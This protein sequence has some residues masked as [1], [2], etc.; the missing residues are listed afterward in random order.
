VDC[1]LQW[2]LSKGIMSTRRK[3]WL[4]AIG[5]FALG[6]LAA[7]LITA[8]M[9]AVRYQPYI[10]E[11]A[12][13]YL[14]HR[15]DSEVELAALRVVMPKTSLFRMAMTRGRG[16]HARVEG[17]GILMRHRGRRDIPPMF[18]MKRFSFEVDLGTVFDDTKV[19]PLVTLE[20]MEITIP[21]KGERPA[22]DAGGNSPATDM[23]IEVMIKEVVISDA[24]LTIL[25]KDKGKT[26][27]QFD[28]H[29]LRL[30]SAGKGVAMNYDAAL[31][32]AKPPGEIL[33]NGHLG[34][35]VAD[36]PGNTPLEGQYNFDKADLG[37]FKGIAGIL[38]STG[39][40]TGTLDSI[41]A[42]GK[43]S[44]PDFRLKI[45][46]NRVPLST[47]FEAL[48]D[49]TN[50]NTVLKPVVAKLGTTNFTTS[51]AII[52]HEGH[53]F[54]TISLDVLMPKGNLKDLLRL[55]L[56]GTPFMEGQIALKTKIDIPPLSGR[57]R[58]KLQLAGNFEVT[59]GKFLRSRIQDKI[60][61]LSRR[62]QGQPK[63]EE[64]DEVISRMKGVFSLE[65][66]VMTFHTLS[67]GVPGADVDLAGNYTF[68]G[69]LD[70]HGTLKLK[71]R[72][73][74][75]MT[76]WKR[77]VLKPVDPFFAKNGAGTFLR[78]KV[79]GTAADPQFGRDAKKKDPI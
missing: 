35:W 25:P 54:R 71:A 1:N 21:P 62:G 8:R 69:P 70:F 75:T 47:Q 5:V 49:G 55:A 26:S 64:I 50:G 13:D 39:T 11:Q 15:F 16:V 42:R 57:V 6:G 59:G 38:N 68:D 48:I 63:N 41:T 29:R 19:V 77:W 44:V 52:K 22:Y 73:S 34:P 28:I 51:G 31:T 2:F 66:E 46:G 72:V 56:K 18:A 74:Q 20:G 27:L 32:N 30:E 40:F 65:D 43:A 53:Q 61:T 79:D 60:D 58:E 36:E 45:S 67:F 17:E 9:L 37:V 24:M 78:I 10:R 3:R 33:S 76:G 12:I 14:R 7:L 4:I 23:N